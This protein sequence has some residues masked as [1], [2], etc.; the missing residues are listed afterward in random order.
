MEILSRLVSKQVSSLPEVYYSPLS[1]LSVFNLIYT[2]QIWK[3]PKLWVGFMKCTLL[4]KPQSFGVLLQV[5]P[6]ASFKFSSLRIFN[7]ATTLN[8]CFFYQQFNSVVIAYLS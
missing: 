5:C 3:Y 8:F 7:Q 2:M 1:C 6:Q 4:T